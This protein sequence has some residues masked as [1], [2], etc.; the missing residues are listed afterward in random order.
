ME[1]AIHAAT[2]KGLLGENILGSEFSFKL[3]LK[4]GAGA[5]VCGEETALIASLEGRRGMPRSRPPFPAVRGLHDCPTNINNVE[6]LAN[7]P[8][9]LREGGDVFA[10]RGTPDSTGT[11]TFALA[12]KIQRPGL[13]E[14]P[15]G[16]P[17]R[18]IVYDVGGGIPDGK[19][20]KAVQTGGPSGGCIPAELLDLPVDYQKLVEAGAIMGSGGMVVMDEETCMVEIARYFVD[21]TQ[22]ESCGKCVP[23]RLGTRQMLQI[24]SDI[25]TGNA[26]PGD[27]ALLEE[28][29]AAV[30]AGS[31]CGLGQTA[32]NPVLTTLRYFKD[33]YDAHIDDGKCP[34]GVCGALLAFSIDPEACVGCTACAKACPV[35]AIEGEKKKVHIIDQDTCVSCG[36]CFKAC[37]FGAVL[38]E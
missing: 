8:A 1:R 24:V 31:L 25:T 7:I 23:C 28:L 32:P 35:D 17:L 9:I 20:F 5:F 18:E 30:K 12:G 36:S 33:E 16:M 13:V 19:A 4:K 14:V 21:F 3:K 27:M 6:T 26:K 2:E 37:K 15:L 29:G 22:K 38:K 34:A 11:K 10:G